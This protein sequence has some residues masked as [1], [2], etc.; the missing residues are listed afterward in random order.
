MLN[1]ILCVLSA[2]AFISI[3]VANVYE[4]IRTKKFYAKLEAD[5]NQI[6]DMVVKEH[7][8]EL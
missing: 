8:G 5:H 2:L 1:T 7:S 4:I 6:M 3:V